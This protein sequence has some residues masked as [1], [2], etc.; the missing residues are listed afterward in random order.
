MSVIRR[1][2]LFPSAAHRDLRLRVSAARQITATAAL[3]QSAA[4]LRAGL[5]PPDPPKGNGSFK[6][7]PQLR[8]VCKPHQ[9]SSLPS[10]FLLKCPLPPFPPRSRCVLG[11]G[12]P[13]AYPR[14]SRL[15][16]LSAHTPTHPQRVTVCPHVCANSELSA[17][18]WGC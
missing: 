18:T 8:A 11:L 7:T 3:R 14:C 13:Q 4:P 12:S 1:L 5:C 6:G 16:R 10:L 9:T 15:Q 17:G 2:C